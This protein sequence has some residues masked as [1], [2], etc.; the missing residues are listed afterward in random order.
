MKAGRIDSGNSVRYPVSASIVAILLGIALR[1]LIRL[2][3]Q[4]LRIAQGMPK[5]SIPPS[6]V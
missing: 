4:L 3:A 5:R 1:N 2:P 6:I